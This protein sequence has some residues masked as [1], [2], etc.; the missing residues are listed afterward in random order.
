MGVCVGGVDLLEGQPLFLAHGGAGFGGLL[1]P[2]AGEVGHEVVHVREAEELE[3]GR[4]VCQHLVRRQPAVDLGHDEEVLPGL[5]K[6]DPP[7]I[8]RVWLIFRGVCVCDSGAV[9]F[10]PYC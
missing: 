3:V 6:V 7:P 4:V 10:L 1:E 2:A 5:A 9:F 8:R